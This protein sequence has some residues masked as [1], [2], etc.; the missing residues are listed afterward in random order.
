MKVYEKRT[1]CFN[2]QE[3]A[4]S[5]GS[6]GCLGFSF[7]LPLVTLLSRTRIEGFFAFWIAP[8]A[9]SDVLIRRFIDLLRML[10]SFVSTDRATESSEGRQG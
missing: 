6:F 4:A 9:Q 7:C 8:S 1:G 10:Q 5:N 3:L 2:P